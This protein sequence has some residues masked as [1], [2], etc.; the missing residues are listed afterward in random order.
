MH[1]YASLFTGIE[2]AGYAARLLGMPIV[3]QSEIDPYCNRVLARHYPG[4]PNLGDIQTADFTPFAGMVGFLVGGFPCQDISGAG[5]GAGID[6]SRSGLWRHYCRAIDDI[7]PQYAIVENSPRLTAKGLDQVLCDLDALGYDA[8]WECFS[9]G[10][11]GA[12]HHRERIWLLTYPRSHR[13]PG[14]LRMLKGVCNRRFEATVSRPMDGGSRHLERFAEG[15][16]ESPVFGIYDGLTRRLHVPNRL[17]AVGNSMY[18]PIPY[19]I[20][21]SVIEVESLTDEQWLTLNYHALCQ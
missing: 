4:V 6:G 17:K 13:R 20:M 15:Y 9:A 18:W 8:E 14:V 21:K 1:T 12:C 3:F 11:Y 7:R 5:A 10:L 2:T 16:G 19:T